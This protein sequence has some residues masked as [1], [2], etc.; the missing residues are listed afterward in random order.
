M[1]GR[2]VANKVSEAVAVGAGST[3]PLGLFTA[4]SVGATAASATAIA[5]TDMFKLFTSMGKAYQKTGAWVVSAPLYRQ[6]LGWEDTAGSYML[7]PADHA[8]NS[9]LGRPLYVETNV[10]TQGTGSNLAA[11]EVHCCFGDVSQF[12]VRTTPMM[13]KHDDGGDDFAKFVQRIAFAV[14]IDSAL[15]VPSAVKSL[16]TAAGQ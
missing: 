7:R 4:A 2:A 10:T 15:V 5:P 16:K 13:F 14:W 1:A 6:M 12:V 3:E 9:F 8:A 11:G